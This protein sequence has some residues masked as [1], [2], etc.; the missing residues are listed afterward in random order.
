MAYTENDLHIIM[1]ALD[2][3]KKVYPDDAKAINEVMD[4]T[5]ARLDAMGA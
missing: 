5:D 1:D 3:L 4:K 2:N